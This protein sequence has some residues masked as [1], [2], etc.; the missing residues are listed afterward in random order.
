MNDYTGAICSLNHK[1][2]LP[3]WYSKQS[4]QGSAMFAGS[5]EACGKIIP[6]SYVQQAQ[7]ARKSRENQIR[8][9]LEHVSDAILDHDSN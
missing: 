5:F 8:T 1:F 4:V 9:F 7:N 6:V 3:P 2:L